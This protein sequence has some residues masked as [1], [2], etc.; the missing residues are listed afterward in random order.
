MW[1]RRRSNRRQESAGAAPLPGTHD[2]VVVVGASAG[3]LAAAEGLRRLGHRG[4]ITMIGAEPHAPYDRLQL[5][6]RLLADDWEPEGPAL[7]PDEVIDALD[8]HFL[9]GFTATRV[10]TAARRVRLDDG[11]VLTYDTL[12][13]AT[14][15]RPRLLPGASG[16]SGVHV[17]RTLEDAAALRARLVPG[18][19]LVIV[20]GGFIG[21][22]V[23]AAARTLG[24]EVTLLESGDAPLASAV[25]DTAG[26]FL[27]GEHLAH[28]VTI[29]SGVRVA[30]VVGTDGVATGV[31]LADGS[32]IA[33]D[34]VLVAIGVVP[35]TEWLDGS[36]LPTADGLVCDEYGC[37][38]PGV[39]G[40]G[41]VARWH[42]PGAGPDVRIEHRANAD[43]QGLAV[44]RA[45][46]DPES[47]QPFTP[48]PYVS[49]EQYDLRIETF[50]QLQGHDEAVVVEGAVDERHFLIAYRRDDRLS[51]VLGVG[52]IPELLDRWRSLV[53]ERAPWS[54][55]VSDLVVR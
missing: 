52:A 18:R 26:T 45:V 9:L 22:E 47:H 46:L 16:L 49:S 4:P 3:G 34:E 33:A 24:V 23:A 8:V 11:S 36:G 38:A 37:A 55:A 48:M 13:V 51:G 15:V 10:D 14:G 12:V 7:R 43:E 32:E 6:R 29:R 35:N 41:D 40:V 39:Y 21:V 50:G 17:L 54:T 20:G 53:T 27:A 42:N 44:A 31:R 5:T 28:G 19:H 30:G 1:G 25:G 2:R